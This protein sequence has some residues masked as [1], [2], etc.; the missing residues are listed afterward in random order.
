MKWESK[1]REP[2]RRSLDEPKA[3][4]RSTREKRREHSNRL[5]RI[6][7]LLEEGLTE[8]EIVEVANFSLEE[9]RSLAKDCIVEEMRQ[10]AGMQ[11]EEVY[12]RYVMESRGNIRRCDELY[13]RFQQAEQ[14]SGLV[15][16]ISTRQK[17]VESVLKNGQ[18]MGFVKKEPNKHFVLTANLSSG[19]LRSYVAESLAKIRADMVTAGEESFDELAQAPGAPR[20]AL[21]PPKADEKIETPMR[22]ELATPSQG[23]VR[24]KAARPLAAGRS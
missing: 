18:S 23:V 3:D 17:I 2:S 8:E 22:G 4:R 21:P 10:V 1:W 14:V 20:I 19:E 11:P 13:D 24:R 6:R 7:A 5:I 12:A 15:G 9:V 16:L